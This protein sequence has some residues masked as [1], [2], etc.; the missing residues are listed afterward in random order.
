MY[1]EVRRAVEADASPDL[2]APGFDLAAHREEVRLANLAQ[3]RE[4]VATVEDVD[5]DGV[6]C[7]L[8]TPADALPGLVVHAHG[9]GFVLNDVDVHDAISRRFA[10]RVRRPVL[11]VDYRRPPEARFPAAPDDLDTVV[12]W[13]R[14]EGPAG[15][16]AAHGDSAG[17]NLALVAALRNPGFFDVVALVYPFLDPR[18]SFP[19]WELGA[20]NGFDPS[21]ATWYWEQYARTEADYD[22]P[23]LAPLLSDRLGTLPPTFVATAEADPLRDEGEELAR[24]VAETGVE[25]VGIRCLGQTH[26]FWRHAAFTASEPLVRSVSGWIDQHLS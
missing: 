17:A 7:R 20:A 25:T 14:R 26:G 2:R 15:P 4:D 18:N 22:D 19:S 13:L 6:P 9:G 24:L 23:D 8:Y 12:A 11:S 10:N 21:E 5:A 16:Y 1:P 3:P